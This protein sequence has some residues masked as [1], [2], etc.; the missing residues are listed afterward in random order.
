MK[1][2]YISWFVSVIVLLIVIIWAG[3]QTRLG[4]HSKRMSYIGILIDERERFSLNRLQLVMWTVLILSTLLGMLFSNLDSAKDALDIPGYLLGL[5]G[6][7]AASAVVSGAVKDSKNATVSENITGGES[8]M[9]KVPGKS[10]VDPQIPRFSQVFLEE[11]GAHAQGQIV[12][13]TKFQ[14]FIFTLVLG[15]IYIVLTV[16]AGEYPVFHE[17]TLWLL[18]IS[19]S[20]YIAGKIP[21]KS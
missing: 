6:I 4:T 14:N 7:S 10:T 17:K 11:E 15:I 18:G 3:R 20:T 1:S 21:N 12:S 13:I 9:K 2:F 19:H 5:L 8:F 16:K